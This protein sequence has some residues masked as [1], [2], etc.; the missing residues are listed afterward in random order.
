MPLIIIGILRVNNV[1]L[2]LKYSLLSQ[3]LR[4]IFI[5]LMKLIEKGEVGGG[6][7]GEREIEGL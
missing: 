5:E 7:R 3:L 4:S 6:R 1:Y 2:F